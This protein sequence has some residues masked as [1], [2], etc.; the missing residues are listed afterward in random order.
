[1]VSAVEWSESDDES[2]PVRKD[3]RIKC[4]EKNKRKKTAILL[5]GTESDSDEWRTMLSTSGTVDKIKFHF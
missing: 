1:M 3:L 2:L 5:S 4:A